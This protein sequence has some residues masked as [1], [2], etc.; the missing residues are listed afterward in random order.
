MESTFRDLDGGRREVFISHASEDKDAIA[1]PLAEELVRRGRSVWFDEYE[2]LL[3]DS[4][5]R[6]ID[7]GLRESAI[8]VVIL[9]RAFFGK[10]WPERELDGLTTRLLAGD[11]H[12]IVPI[13]HELTSDD[14]RRYSP[15]LADL[16]AARSQ[17]GV[18]RLA[19]E[20]ERVLDRKDARS[21]QL[22]QPRSA[23]DGAGLGTP[24]RRDG[25]VLAGPDGAL[26]TTA[27]GARFRVPDR[28]TAAWLFPHEHVRGVSQSTL[29][30]I[31]RT[32]RDGS[33]LREEPGPIFL[34]A[35]GAKLHVPDPWTLAR[36]FDG[37][38][39]ANL[40][41]G[42]LDDLPDVPRDG[43][44]LR[45]E[46]DPQVYEIRGGTRRRV[47]RDPREAL[48]LWRHALDRFPLAS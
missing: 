15:P 13:W 1:R 26:W 41:Q 37:M 4:L 29:D 44:L 17:E 25:S 43:T 47:E 42:A 35:G 27:G 38:R 40:W 34:I 18:D 3:G 46:L 28:E 45:A 7:A 9:S 39:V 48:L 8:G 20:I 12:A 5:R 22:P 24:A 14:V 6:T 2:L 30:E 10:P 16:L 11:S 31:S 33:L 21:A 32:P 23:D 36:L 19:D